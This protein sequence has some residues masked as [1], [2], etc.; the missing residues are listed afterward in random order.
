E[1]IGLHGPSI[2][3]VP[4]RCRPVDGTDATGPAAGDVVELVL[5]GGVVANAHVLHGDGE[6]AGSVL[7]A[8]QRDE[9]HRSRTRWYAWSRHVISSQTGNGPTCAVTNSHRR[10]H[11]PAKRRAW[12]G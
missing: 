1:V 7:L 12:A 5:E 11:V 8:G 3:G 10:S 6:Q 2:D 9:S 4:H